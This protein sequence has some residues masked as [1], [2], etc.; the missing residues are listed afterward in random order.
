MSDHVF[1]VG[2]LDDGH[3]FTGYVA[4][5]YLAINGKPV[6]DPTPG[7]SQSASIFADRS[8]R[9]RAIGSIA[10]PNNYLVVPANYTEQQAKA[11]A[12]EIANTI[13][14]AGWGPAL[15]QMR[16]AFKQFGS[17]D[18]Q[19]NPQWGIPNGSVVPAF[20]S[21]A[22]YHLGSVTRLAG[23]PKVL[24]EIGGGTANRINA[25]VVQPVKRLLGS[26]SDPIDT[27]GDI[28]GLSMQNYANFSKGYSDAAV[29]RNAAS[30]MNDFG[31]RP[32]AQYPAGQIGD[33]NGLGVGDW[34]FPLAGV[35]PTNPT[36]P[37]PPPQSGNKS[38]PRLV[39]VNGNTLPASSAV[40]VVPSDNRNSFDNRFGN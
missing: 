37:V 31:Y 21:S 35:D 3:T 5:K 9:Y 2:A 1:Y 14:K 12:A 23:L 10:N 7:G 39:R 16:D 38:V 11:F 19:R 32:L 13:R 18:L 33:G 36:Q 25:D 4:A 24:S 6:V 30:P 22:S 40:P 20:V 29:A 27:N 26:K 28:W 8:H 34:R 15:V 17:Q